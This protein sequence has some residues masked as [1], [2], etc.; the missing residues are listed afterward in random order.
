[1]HFQVTDGPSFLGSEGVP[2]V[3]QSFVVEGVVDPTAK[4]FGDTAPW[5][6]ARNVKPS[7]HNL[8]IPLKNSVVDFP[9]TLTAR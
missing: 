1:L 8:E 7:Q 3:F 6:P 4:G 9:D 2:Y 5:S